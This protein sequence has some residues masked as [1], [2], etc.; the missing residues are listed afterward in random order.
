M[1]E[2]SP[3]FCQ[4]QKDIQQTWC[5]ND[6][7]IIKTVKA[8]VQMT[9]ET[10]LSCSWLGHTEFYTRFF[11]NDELHICMFGSVVLNSS[12]Q[13]L[14]ST[15]VTLNQA[16]FCREEKSVHVKSFRVDSSLVFLSGRHDMQFV[17]SIWSLTAF[18]EAKIA[19]VTL[20]ANPL[21]SIHAKSTTMSDSGIGYHLPAGINAIETRD[22]FCL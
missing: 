8:V 22:F 15:P 2:H 21:S 7:L 3:S 10:R 6:A 17:N 4:K 16:R 13:S 9:I 12:A 5:P 1:F 14:L 19:S 11:F 20:T 18:Q